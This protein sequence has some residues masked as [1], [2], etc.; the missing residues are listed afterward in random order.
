MVA[1]G[2]GGRIGVSGRIAG[3]EKVVINEEVVKGWWKERRSIDHTAKKCEAIHRSEG[4]KSVVGRRN[5][6]D[7]RDKGPCWGRVP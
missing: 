1:M 5:E 6:G 2:G 4:W 3:C 7:E